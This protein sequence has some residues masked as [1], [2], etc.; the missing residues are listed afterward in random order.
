[1]AA[2]EDGP[3][4]RPFETVK[5]L[6]DRLGLKP[7][8]TWGLE[9]EA[10]LVAEIETLSGVVLVC[11]EH[12]RIISAILPAL[13]ANSSALPTKWDGQRFDVVLR[14]DRAAPGG[15]WS[16]RE[17]FP[18]LLSGDSDTPL[19]EQATLSALPG[20]PTTGMRPPKP[21]HA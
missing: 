2:T 8:T 5:P 13:G 1:V 21:T 20:D 3:S 11:W 9:Q 14:F 7:V 17:L 6:A 16:F 12:K 15:D 18:Q 10:K 4:Q 19:R